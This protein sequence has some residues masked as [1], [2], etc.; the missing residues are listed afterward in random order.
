MK[1]DTPELAPELFDLYDDYAHGKLDRR[2]FLQAA[3]RYATGGLGAVALLGLLSPDYSRANQVAPGDPRIRTEWVEVPSPEGH[4][5]VRSY[6]VRPR[7]SEP[8][9]GVVVV[10]ENRG[11]N[12]YIQD[13]A[14]RL[15][16]AGF[17]ALAPDGLSSLGGYPGT[18]EEGKAMQRT[19]D[20]QT[21]LEDFLAAWRF[22][23]SHPGCNGRVGAVG[24]CFGGWVVNH[25]AVRLPELAA[26]V[27]FYG[28]QPEAAEVHRI[29]APLLLH[30]AEEDPR[31]NQGWPAYQEALQGLGIRHSV[32]HYPG[33]RHGF[34]NDTTPR[35]DPE[36]AD[37][38]WTR[39]LDFFR[40]HL[41]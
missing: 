35:F 36:A 30:Y 26:G 40:E 22:L 41:G 25:M 4:G 33:V 1:Q 5:T 21:L 20:R 15:A 31:V 7:G 18:D 29:R 12:P 13:V 24:F 2:G 23:C 32:H 27:P 34:H 28:T 10:H 38:A 19:L 6:L 3:A 17:L 37:L 8:R 11:L 9:G 16:A 14:R 39:T